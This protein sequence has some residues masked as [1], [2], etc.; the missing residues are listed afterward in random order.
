MSSDFLMRAPPGPDAG[1][2]N[3][4]S[5]ALTKRDLLTIL[6]KHWFIIL[7][8]WLGVSALVAWA[9]VSLP[10]K[11]VAEAK[12]LVKIEQQ[13]R[14]SFLSGI[15]AYSETPDIEPAN[16][17]LETEMEIMLSRPL[18]ERVVSELN[19]QPDDMYRPPYVHLLKPLSS[20]TTFVSHSILGLSERPPRDF[21]TTV[22]AFAKS[23][24]VAPAKSKSG[25]ATPNLIAV[26][27]QAATPQAAYEG[28][29]RLMLHYQHY[30]NDLDQKSGERVVTVVSAQLKEAASAVEIAQE[31]IKKFS[32][33]VRNAI[34]PGVAAIRMPSE[35]SAGDNLPGA[36]RQPTSEGLLLSLRGRVAELEIQLAEQKRLYTDKVDSISM[37]KKSLAEARQRLVEQTQESAHNA[38]QLMTLQ[39]TLRLAEDHYLDLKHK[40][41]QVQLFLEMNPDQVTNRVII[42]PP[43][44]P[45]ESEWKKSLVFGIAA[46]LAGLLF[47]LGLASMREYADH[48]LTTP[49]D[50]ER[51]TGLPLLITVD[52]MDKER[53]RTFIGAERKVGM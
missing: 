1:I 6:F 16:R 5:S 14:P 17:K 15:A 9:L 19:L 35:R 37:L 20:L 22:S 41:T 13:G 29:S 36:D 39:R 42:E 4:R 3:E 47:G 24:T 8:C 10:P 28:L 46:S 2:A 31:E 52:A 53:L 38:N 45:A 33:Q 27:F 12:V 30:S 43:Q 18:I 48:R 44:L 49:G 7:L 51:Y 26:R 34:D 40:L 50:V 23:I 11:Y 21:E 25:E 32:A